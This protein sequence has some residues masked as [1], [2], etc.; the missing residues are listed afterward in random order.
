MSSQVVSLPTQQTRPLIIDGLNWAAVTRDQ[1]ERTLQGGVT[2]IN[3]TAVQPWSDLSKSLKELEANLSAIE[4]MS[5][6][7]LVV[8]T[9]DDIEKAHQEQKLGVIIGAQNSLMV[10]GDVTLLA[11]FKRLGMRILQPTYNEPCAFGQ[12][13]PDMG[14]ADKGITEAGRAWVAEMHKIAY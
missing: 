10:E 8:H 11:T 3:L 7:A 4:A 1:F 9:I 14:E 6:I 13:A 2:A 5:D 12:G